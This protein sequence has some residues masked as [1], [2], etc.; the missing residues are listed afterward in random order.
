MRKTKAEEGETRDKKGR[1]RSMQR[2]E[3]YNKNVGRGR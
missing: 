3:T 1:E 2:K